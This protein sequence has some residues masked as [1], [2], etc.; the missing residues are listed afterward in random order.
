MSDA[1]SVQLCA[2]A[3]L[4]LSKSHSSLVKRSRLL[5]WVEC[6]VEILRRL[7]MHVEAKNVILVFSRIDGEGI[8]Q[9]P[10][11]PGLALVSVGCA[12]CNELW[13]GQCGHQ[14]T[15][16]GL[17]RQICTGNYVWCNGCGHG[18]HMNEYAS[19]FSI[20]N[21]QCP[22]LGCGHVCIV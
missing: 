9:S 13:T 22:V 10:V 6:Y 18:G 17:C 7:E 15:R 1:G 12:T 19:W 3:G 16:C 20:S 5:C 11:D 4:L 21:K 14:A 2:V 8:Q